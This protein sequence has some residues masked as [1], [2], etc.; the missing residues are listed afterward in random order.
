MKV[1]GRILGDEYILDATDGQSAL[2]LVDDLPSTTENA[3][4]S[5]QIENDHGDDKAGSIF[6]NEGTSWNKLTPPGDTVKEVTNILCPREGCDVQIRWTDPLD[7]NKY[8]WK[9]TRL[10]RKFGTEPPT[11]I[12]DGVVVTDSYVRDQYATSP[13]HDVLPSGTEDEY[14]ENDGMIRKWRYRFFTFSEDEVDFTS[15][16][17]TFEPI[18]LSW[19]TLPNIVRDGLSTKVFQTGDVVHVGC[20]D[21]S[22]D[23]Y[24]GNIEFEV[25]AFDQAVPVDSGKSH[26]LTFL[27]RLVL[28]HRVFFDTKWSDYKLTSDQYVMDRNK[29]YF[30][31]ISETEYTSVS[32]LRLGS[33]IPPNTYYEKT[34]SEERTLHGGNRWSTSELRRWLNSTD[35]EDLMEFAG[36]DVSFSKIAPP[37]TKLPVDV[38]NAI[39]SVRNKTALS[40]VD[41]SVYD[42]SYDSIYLLSATEVYG[43]VAQRSHFEITKDIEPVESYTITSDTVR[44]M[45]KTYFIEDESGGYRK[46]ISEFNEDGSFIED[47]KY[48]ELIPK[49]YY[50]VDERE[51]GYRVAKDEDFADGYAFKPDEIYYELIV[52][53]TEEN[54]PNFSLFYQN[55]EGDTDLGSRIRTDLAGDPK[56]WWLRTCD[57]TSAS[58]VKAVDEIGK[59]VNGGNAAEAAQHLVIAFTVA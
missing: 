3:T 52:D 59:F 26:S 43:I 51:S 13:F 28:G 53:V 14:L 25:A 37:L 16:D 30:I 22:S 49:Q 5:V 31:K 42:V 57:T 58:M 27:A 54:S 15:V 34:N 17:C 32:G 9:H 55:Y 7:T 10:L 19:K 50:V 21:G 8:V 18:E 2:K 48:F 24:Y 29:V 1:L 56:A 11:S 35:P 41:G 4:G 6:L 39:A 20:R 40:I 12:F 47:L 45:S 46:A 36:D 44:D 23:E 33:K 38:V